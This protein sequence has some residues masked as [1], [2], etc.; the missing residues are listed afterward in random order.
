MTSL[1]PVPTGRPVWSHLP[2]AASW[3]VFAG[4][5]PATASKTAGAPFKV[6]VLISMSVLLNGSRHARRSSSACPIL[7]FMNTHMLAG[8]HAQQAGPSGCSVTSP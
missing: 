1:T 2:A 5:K 6:A 3:W 4:S 7:A 8:A